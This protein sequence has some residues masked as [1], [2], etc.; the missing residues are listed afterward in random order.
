MESPT[1]FT[2]ALSFLPYE[3]GNALDYALGIQSFESREKTSKRG[4]AQRPTKSMKP[5]VV[6][7]CPLPSSLLGKR[8]SGESGP[9]LLTK[10]I[11]PRKGFEQG[12][13]VYDL[14]AGMGQDSLL[15]ANAGAKRVHMVERDPIVAALLE[16]AL[17]R[18]HVL[19]EQ[20]DDDRQR[21]LATDL[22]RCLSLEVKDGRE[23]LAQFMDDST[24][25]RPDIVYLDPMFPARKKSAS[26]KKNMQVL[27]GLLETRQVAEEERLKEESELLQAAYHAT[28]C[29]VVV[30][31]P[32]NA[33][34][35]G[36]SLFSTELKPSYQIKGSVNRWDVY[37][38][39]VL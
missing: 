5:F 3:S 26:V 35:L 37:V 28:G 22:W 27:Q 6:D 30:K 11:A 16:D 1:K 14:M 39:S 29:R 18:L 17:R 13:I 21:Q 33:E 23:V 25:E 7:F 8:S 20:A 15:I 4:K 31:R 24:K 36:G 38:K 9:D 12:A 32:V 34:Q 2:H 10:A 19:S